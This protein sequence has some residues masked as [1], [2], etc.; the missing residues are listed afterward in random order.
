MP[1]CAD[2]VLSFAGDLSMVGPLSARL[3]LPVVHSELDE[4]WEAERGLLP[5]PGHGAAATGSTALPGSCPTAQLL[6]QEECRLL[7]VRCHP[8]WGCPCASDQRK[9]E[10]QECALGHGGS[11][12]SMHGAQRGLPKCVADEGL[13]WW[14]DKIDADTCFLFLFPYFIRARASPGC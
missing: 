13:I 9:R 11:P 2:D 3:K 5:A 12:F 4:P 14:V 7:K 1:L 10:K 6:E 8:H